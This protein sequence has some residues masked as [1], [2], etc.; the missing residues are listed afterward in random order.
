MLVDTQSLFDFLMSNPSEK[1]CIDYFEKVAWNGQPTSPFDPTSKVYKVSNKRYQYKC[2]NTGKYFN[3]RTSTVLKGS[4]IEIKKWLFAL[5]LFSS[6]RI[7]SYQLAKHINVAQKSAWY[8]E[9]R[10]RLAFDS[11]AFKAKL[12]NVVEIDETY[13]GG[14]NPNR[15]WNKKVPHSQGRSWKDKTP[16]LVMV[17]KGGNLIA[18]V[19][20]NVE[21]KTLVPIIRAN[22]REGSD[23]HTDEWKA[24]NN[25]KKWYNHQV[26]NHRFKQYVNGKVSVNAAENFN[27]H[28]KRGI[29]GTYYQISRQHS[30]RYVDESAFR[31]NT[32]KYSIKERFDL[33]LASTVGKK[34]TYKE[35]TSA[36]AD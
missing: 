2:K 28:L 24:Y 25:L 11:P 32:R 30:Q 12:G 21:Q 17:E 13:M 3:I 1:D 10:L 7:S 18:R 4:R 14:A 29:Y 20:P 36:C 27:S 19:V 6:Q 5:L 8:V 31:H 33:A 26:V 23:I 22:I 15:H 35:L 9:H 34:L 16:T